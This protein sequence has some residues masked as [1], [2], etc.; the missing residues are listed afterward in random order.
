MIW[1]DC[2]TPTIQLYHQGRGNSAIGK[3]VFPH[4]GFLPKNSMTLS[5]QSCAVITVDS[6]K[7][8][9]SSTKLLSSL[10]NSPYLFW[11]CARLRAFLTKCKSSYKESPVETCNKFCDSICFNILFNSSVVFVF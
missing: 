5:K 2:H 6:V 11:I 9:C 10:S 4:Q 8:R 7:T 3:I 1:G